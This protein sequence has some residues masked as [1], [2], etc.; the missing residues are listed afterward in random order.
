M[1]V[2]ITTSVILSGVH[3]PFKGE[4]DITVIITKDISDI[5]GPE[6]VVVPESLVAM[7]GTDTKTI[8]E[9]DGYNGIDHNKVFKQAMELA[10]EAYA[11]EKKKDDEKA[12][13]KAQA[14]AKAKESEADRKAAQE[15]KDKKKAEKLAEKKRKNEERAKA[16]TEKAKSK[17]KKQEPKAPA[18]SEPKEPAK[19]SKPEP[20]A[21][22]KPELGKGNTPLEKLARAN[23]NVV[24]ATVK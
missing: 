18:K 8:L 12:K 10:N 9:K 16:L 1:S 2:I 22:H 3:N 19:S 13:R 15:A 5:N 14:E 24:F 6:L 11:V 20:K 21:G 17:E 4:K 23:G 7:V